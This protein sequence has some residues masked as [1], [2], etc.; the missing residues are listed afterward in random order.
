M[1]GL[2]DA[3]D[4]RQRP[5]VDVQFLAEDGAVGDV[6]DFERGPRGSRSTFPPRS[7]IESRSTFASLPPLLEDS[8]I[9]LVLICCI[10]G[11]CPTRGSFAMAL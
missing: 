2:E 4:G 11:A 8:S 10:T 6:F 1:L 9:R 3:V 5:L 7:P